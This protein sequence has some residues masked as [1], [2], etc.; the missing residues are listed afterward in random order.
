[1]EHG[2]HRIISIDRFL[3]LLVAF[4]VVVVEEVLNVIVVVL[5][6]C[7]GELAI[8]TLKPKEEESRVY[9]SSV[10]GDAS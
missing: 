9:F 6:I 1:M 2:P 4:L 3:L 8:T 5:G 10:L 7:L